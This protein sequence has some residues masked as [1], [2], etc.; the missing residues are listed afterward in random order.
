MTARDLAPCNTL[1]LAKRHKEWKGLPE[2]VSGHRLT[3]LRTDNGGEFTSTELRTWLK[4]KGVTQEF[5]PPR[6]SQANGVAE[7][8][9]R[10]L[11]EMA[12][13]MMQSTG[14]KGG[15]RGRLS[16]SQ[17]LAQQGTSEGSAVYTSGDVEWE[18][19]LHLPP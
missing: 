5:T 15:A 10:T 9:N 19:A 7:R 16:C 12:R 17:L 18:E 13:S 11:Q 6:T 8:L 2:N 1:H 4:E 3:R 14:L